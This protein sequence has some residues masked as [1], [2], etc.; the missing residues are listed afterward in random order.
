MAKQ[1]KDFNEGE[2]LNVNLL[3]SNLVKGT[4]NSGAPYLSITLQD[5]T[6]SL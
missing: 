4:T 2:R 6:K 1:V 3:I 5:C